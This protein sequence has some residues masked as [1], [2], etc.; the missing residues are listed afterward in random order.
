MTF[1]NFK[2][3]FKDNVCEDIHRQPIIRQQRHLLPELNT[4]FPQRKSSTN[5]SNSSSFNELKLFKNSTF[6]LQWNTKKKE[7]QTYS[8]TIDFHS[9][10][11]LYNESE[12][13]SSVFLHLCSA[14]ER[15]A[16]IRVW[17]NM[18]VNKNLWTC[19]P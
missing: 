15:K 3:T 17:S 2:T 19:F 9:M 18:R 6:F 13:K 7:T 4:W 16:V 8:V 10:F 11:S 5:N 1:C 12:R 14:E